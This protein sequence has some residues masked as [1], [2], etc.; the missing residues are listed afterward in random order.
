MKEPPRGDGEGDVSVGSPF[1]FRGVS[2]CSDSLQLGQLT[3]GFVFSKRSE[4]RMEGC[5]WQSCLTLRTPVSYIGIV[6][7]DDVLNLFKSYVM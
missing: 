1:C 3:V 7:Y 5:V 2:L 4:I 6:F